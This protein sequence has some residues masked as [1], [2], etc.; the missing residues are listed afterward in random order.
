MGSSPIRVFYCFKSLP[1]RAGE[2]KVTFLFVFAFADF[3]S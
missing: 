2:F 3:L 1:L